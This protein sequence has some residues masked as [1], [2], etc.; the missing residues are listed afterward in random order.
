MNDTS[1]EAEAVLMRIWST[2]P[3]ERKLAKALGW[4]RAVRD[5]TREGI[6]QQ[7]PGAS[8]A[9]VERMLADRCLGSE[10]AAKVYGPM[11]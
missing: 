3:P 8:S 2:M 9:Q 10:L 7:H 4:S 5:L 11:H 1:P 6:R